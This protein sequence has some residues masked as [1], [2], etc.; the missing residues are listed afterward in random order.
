MPEAVV[1]RLEVVQ[2]GHDDRDLVPEALGARDLGAECLVELPAIRQL[3]QLVRRRKLARDPVEVRVLERDRGAAREPFGELDVVLVEPARRRVENEQPA[4]DRSSRERNRERRASAVHRAGS[5]QHLSVG[6]EARADGARDGNGALEDHGRQGIDVVARREDV[7]DECCRLARAP[8]SARGR[9]FI[10]RPAKPPL[11]W[12][13]QPGGEKR[14]EDDRRKGGEDG[15][16]DAPPPLVDRG[17]DRPVRRERRQP[18]GATARRERA[19]PPALD[20]ERARR[21]RE[22]RIAGDEPVA[23]RE[24]GPRFQGCDRNLHQDAAELTH[25][26]DDGRGSGQR[27]FA[28]VSREVA[29]APRE[30]HSRRDGRNP[31]QPVKVV[32]RERTLHLQ[33]RGEANGPRTRL[34]A[35]AAL[36]RANGAAQLSGEPRVRAVVFRSLDAP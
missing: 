5:R 2:V 33:A 12:P 11:R 18:C 31:S 10:G 26:A 1:D 35:Q 8:G 27:T 22:R 14:E 36:H 25:A 16:E 20:L 9:R 17:V 23:R 34:L 3:G 19:I 28:P 15:E 29:V 7:A 30:A 6:H 13:R 24:R 21:R 32:A 4:V